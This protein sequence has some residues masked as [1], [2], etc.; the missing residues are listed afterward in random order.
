MTVL[1]IVAL[2]IFI[3]AGIPCVA[4][5]TDLEKLNAQTYLEMHLH[6]P[7]DSSGMTDLSPTPFLLYLAKSGY[8]DVQQRI[9]NDSTSC[10]TLKHFF[11]AFG[12]PIYAVCASTTQDLVSA[13]NPNLYIRGPGTNIDSLAIF[14]MSS[15]QVVDA[16]V[17]KYI[18]PL[19]AT[20]P[21]IVS[22]P[23]TAWRAAFTPTAGTMIACID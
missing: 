11:N 14:T 12:L 19:P 21:P 17:K 22:G 2:F 23:G 20:Q 9:V 5:A 3:V 6:C 15:G 13:Q 18:L 7:L 1:E 4:S 8:I 10:W 16:W